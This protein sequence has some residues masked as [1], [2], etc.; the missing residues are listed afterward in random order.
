[1]SKLI[2]PDDFY[3]HLAGKDVRI[4]EEDRGTLE[5]HAETIRSI[6]HRTRKTLAEAVVRMGAVLAQAQSQLAKHGDG[7]FAKWVRDRCGISKSTAYRAI[8]VHEAFGDR[9]TVGQTFEPTALYVLSAPSTPEEATE[10]ALDLAG[11]GELIT[12]KKA[13]EIVKQH[14]VVDDEDD[15]DEDDQVVQIS[16]GWDPGTCLTDIRREVEKWRKAC[17]PENLLDLEQILRHFVDQVACEYM[18]WLK[19]NE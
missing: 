18:D 1:M 9:P 13:R 10:E 3:L 5:K 12:A 8:A 16:S 15:Q 4:S 17:G 6:Q 19:A 7:T 14:T 2:R 11:K